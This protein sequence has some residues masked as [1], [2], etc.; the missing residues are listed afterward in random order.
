[1]AILSGTAYWAS[2]TTPNTTFEPVYTVN[3]VVD[4][5]TAESFRSK[6]HTIKD[7]DE[8][9]ALVI[10]RKVNGP[11]GMI[12]S[13]PKLVDS[14]KNPI[15]ERIGNGSEVKIQY[16]EW[17]SVWK[18]KTFKGLDFQAMQ[19][20]DLVSVGSVDGGEFDVEDEMEGT[21]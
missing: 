10:K 2:V 12:R 17:E 18:G 8:G 16:K 20:I 15:D 4:E 6:G 13:A 5:E 19:V 21:I 9:P 7:M 1:M 14:A 11:N 3:L